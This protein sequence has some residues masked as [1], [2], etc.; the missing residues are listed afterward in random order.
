MKTRIEELDSIRGYA[1][2]GILICNISLFHHSLEYFFQFFF[3]NKNTSNELFNFIRFNYFGDRT[4]TVF[5]IL[6]GVGIGMQYQKIKEQGR[7]FIKYHTSRMFVLFLIGLFHTTLIW[8]GDI[9]IL[10]AIIGICIIPLLGEKFKTKLVVAIVLFLIP[11]IKIILARTG[12]FELNFSPSKPQSLAYIINQNTNQGV[13]GHL[14]F[15]L[16]QI[17]HVYDYY[18]SGMVFTCLSMVVFG[19]AI[20]QIK[21][22]SQ[23][24]HDMKHHKK[25]LFICIPIILIWS[26]YQFFIFQPNELESTFDFYLFWLLSNISTLAQTFFVISSFFLLYTSKFSNSI[27]LKGFNKLGKLS[28]TNYILHSV[29]GI[30][31]FKV[32]GFYG[33]SNPTLDFLLSIGLTI[34][35]MLISTLLIAKY[36]RGPLEIIWRKL[37]SLLLNKKQHTTQK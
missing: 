35:Q 11:T 33:Q 37:T 15:N 22:L 8:Y 30:I 21:S 16:S 7:S 26:L 9:L 20:G 4:Y 6:F 3:S 23:E 19:T 13:I 2:F 31:I 25:I 18:A 32:F 10:Y 5:S 36:Q 28:L 17:R 24:L 1:I 34:V 14:K 12:C 29:F 27:I